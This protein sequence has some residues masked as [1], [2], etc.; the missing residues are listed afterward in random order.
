MERDLLKRATAYVG[1][2]CQGERSIMRP[3]S[4]VD[5]PAQV[6]SSTSCHCSLQRPIPG[7]ERALTAAPLEAARGRR[8][9]RS[10]FPRRRSPTR[11]TPW[12]RQGRPR[13]LGPRTGQLC[14]T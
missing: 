9:P 11:A 8:E 5:C 14:S 10:R 2:R 13:H 3:L 4:R 12:V 6:A 7:T 1:D